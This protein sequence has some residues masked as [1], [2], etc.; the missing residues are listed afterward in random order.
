[1]NSSEWP[2][3]ICV[4]W[5]SS[6]SAES[7]DRRRYRRPGSLVHEVYVALA[8]ATQGV[9]RNRHYLLGAAARAKRRVL[10]D[11]ARR[12]R[13]QKRGG[14]QATPKSLAGWFVRFVTEVPGPRS[15]S[16]GAVGG[17]VQPEPTRTRVANVARMAR[18]MTASLCSLV[19][20][21][22]PGDLRIDDLPDL[23]Q[24][25]PRGAIARRPRTPAD[26][27]LE[28]RERLA[29]QRPTGDQQSV[30]R[31]GARA[32]AIGLRVDGWQ[33]TWSSQ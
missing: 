2:T 13:R 17:S 19:G 24:T 25:T 5:R 15:A 10:I 4:R 8:P 20:A 7:T 22:S 3:T 14:D 9:V 33:L 30:I 28:C 23:C 18:V 6:S 16:R 31:D 11:A 12:R 21:R 29:D 1:M 27:Y 32:M 26:G